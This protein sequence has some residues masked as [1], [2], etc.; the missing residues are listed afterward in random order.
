MSISLQ[1]EL[2]VMFVQHDPGKKKLISVISYQLSVPTT[3]LGGKKI[4]NFLSLSRL[5]MAFS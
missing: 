5:D 3:E 4:R 2:K 1:A